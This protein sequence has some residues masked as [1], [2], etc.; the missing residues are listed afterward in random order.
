MR[1]TRFI[2]RTPSAM[3][4]YKGR[5]HTDDLHDAFWVV[6]LDMTPSNATSVCL[7]EMLDLD[8][9]LLIKPGLEFNSGA[10]TKGTDGS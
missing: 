6:H 3:K 8:M 1:A 5:K 10:L 2:L 9:P 7:K 4:M